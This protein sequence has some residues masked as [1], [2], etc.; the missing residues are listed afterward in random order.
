MSAEF[1]L[2]TLCD[3][4][5]SGLCYLVSVLDLPYVLKGSLHHERVQPE[6]C[7]HETHL[8]IADT[9]SCP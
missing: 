5:P 6:T 8:Y 9:G 4:L 1:L 2:L 3:L 7:D